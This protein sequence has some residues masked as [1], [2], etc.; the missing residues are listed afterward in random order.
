[1]TNS[2]LAILTLVNEQPRHGYEIEQVLDERGFREWTEL[3]FSS[4]YYLLK[5]LEQRGWVES[6]AEQIE[7]RPSRR[8]YQLT[9]A[10][11]AALRL[12]VKQALSEPK[13]GGADF[14]LGLANLPLLSPAEIE[15]AI[16]GYR[17]CLAD[18]LAGLQGKRDGAPDRLPFHA[19]V[20]FDLS[21][22]RLQAELD[23]TKGFLDRIKTSKKDPQEKP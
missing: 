4:I 19:G 12:A 11:A 1:M 18:K 17:A 22:A 9:A 10:G 6:Q 3:G 21:L 13:P 5:K 2:E 15:T 7:N 14:L 23:W 20:M 8:V 16:R